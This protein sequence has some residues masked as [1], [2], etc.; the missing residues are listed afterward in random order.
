MV[1][2]IIFASLLA[3]SMFFLFYRLKS[4]WYIFSRAK[5]ESDAIA[6]NFKQK[7]PETISEEDLLT[8]NL[9][10]EFQLL[11]SQCPILYCVVA[12]AMGLGQNQL[13]VINIIN[14]ILDCIC[15]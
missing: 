5:E 1:F 13:E 2:G 9:R 3:R 14:I 4:T 10:N 6:K 12:G 8:F 11:R 15:D 7:T